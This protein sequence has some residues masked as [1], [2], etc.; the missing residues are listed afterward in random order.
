MYAGELTALQRV[1]IFIR[2]GIQRRTVAYA[3]AAVPGN[4]NPFVK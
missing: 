1:N 4:S 3:F 2:M